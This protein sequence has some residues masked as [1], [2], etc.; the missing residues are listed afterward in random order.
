[1]CVL[2]PCVENTCTLAVLWSIEDGYV[3][4][5]Y[6]IMAPDPNSV[7]LSGKFPSFSECIIPVDF[8]GPCVHTGWIWPQ[9]LCGVLVQFVVQSACHV[10]LWLKY[11]NIL[12]RM[13]DSQ[14]MEAERLLWLSNLASYRADWTT[15]LN[16]DTAFETVAK[17]YSI[18]EMYFFCLWRKDWEPWLYMWCLQNCMQLQIICIVFLCIFFWKSSSC[19]VSNWPF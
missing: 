13:G 14:L 8:M 3:K 5:H 16:Y 1:M 4:A 19:T 18:R 6:N 9:L 15:I 11:S 2:N 7:R 12:S 17:V 10:S